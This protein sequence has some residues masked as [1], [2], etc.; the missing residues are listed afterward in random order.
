M[1]EYKNKHNQ[2][3][4]VILESQTQL[5]ALGGMSRQLIEQKS[6]EIKKYKKRCRASAIVIFL[7]LFGA[8]L[9]AGATGMKEMDSA[10]MLQSQQRMVLI[11]SMLFGLLTFLSLPLIICTV[12]FVL[13][14]SRQNHLKR[15]ISENALDNEQRRKKAILQD[16]LEKAEKEYPILKDLRPVMIH[17][18][19]ITEQQVQLAKELGV[20]LS[21]FSAHVYHWGDV[22]IENLG[23]ERAADLSPAAW[24]E[25]YSVP[26]T[27]HQDSP[28][29]E[30]DMLETLWCAVNRETKSG[31]LLGENQK[32]SVLSALKAVTVNA[33]YQYFEENV[34]GSISAGKTADLTVLSADPLEADPNELKNI[35]VLKTISRGKVIYD[36]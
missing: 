20:V 9:G 21:F 30:P 3:D 24:A 19:F 13:N 35:K 31:R 33:V 5:T 25:K 14:K 12:V 27:M 17:A 2:L 15:E 7:I 8:V 16:Q 1:I 22:H 6:A 36:C 4:R 34:K 26:F 28:V 18:Q 11:V 10:H 29:I 23:F 32:I